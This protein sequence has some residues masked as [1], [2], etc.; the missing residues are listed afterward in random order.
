[1]L[2]QSF[3]NRK[4][5][6]KINNFDIFT[7]LNLVSS[8]KAASTSKLKVSPWLFVSHFQK[9]LT[10]I[11]QGRCR[12][13]W[14]EAGC[15][16]G[17]NVLTLSRL[18]GECRVRLGVWGWFCFSGMQHFVYWALVLPST[19]RGVGKQLS[20]RDVCSPWCSRIWIPTTD[21]LCSSVR[22]CGCRRV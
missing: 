2:F 22:W 19:M 14:R 12:E 8:G 17:V 18:L 13:A 9:K 10:K 21:P 7:F 20:V 5:N 16:S 6:G 11:P 1:M 4:A 15:A 3:S